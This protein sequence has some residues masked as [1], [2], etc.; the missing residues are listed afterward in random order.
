MEDDHFT[1]KVSRIPPSNKNK[2]IEVINPKKLLRDQKLESL[3]TEL[4][5]FI[6]KHLQ[7]ISYLVDGNQYQLQI[8]I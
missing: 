5:A 6:D 3:S 8:T 4:H 2:L 7:N 1:P